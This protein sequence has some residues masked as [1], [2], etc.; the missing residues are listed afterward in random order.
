MREYES[1]ESKIEHEKRQRKMNYCLE[2]NSLQN[3]KK[4]CLKFFFHSF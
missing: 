2:I 3:K 4:Q 1:R